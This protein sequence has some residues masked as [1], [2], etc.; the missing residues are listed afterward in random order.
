MNVTVYGRTGCTY[1]DKAKELLEYKEIS[2]NYIDINEDFDAALEL[3]NKYGM[4]KTVPQIVI[5]NEL[6][7]GYTDLVNLNVGK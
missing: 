4:F 2:Y 3:K 6:I 7:G 5:D 1:C